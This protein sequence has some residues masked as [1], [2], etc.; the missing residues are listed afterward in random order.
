MI[1]S[2]GTNE[3]FGRF[4][5]RRFTDS[6]N[7]LVENIKKRNP[8]AAILLTTPIECQRT[9]YTTVKSKRKSGSRRKKSRT[10]SKRVKGYAVNSNILPVRNV[11]LDY[12]KEHKIAVYDWYDVA[13]GSGASGKWISAGL[14]SADRVH[15][16]AQGYRLY[17][18]LMYFA[19]K[20]CLEQK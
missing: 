18:Y 7:R 20:E 1:I 19:L 2:L 16:S 14:F 17:G 6:M 12:A 4:D 15:H 13:G 11:I 10:V 9:T 5:A 3:A 8:N